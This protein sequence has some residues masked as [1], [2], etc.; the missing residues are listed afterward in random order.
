VLRDAKNESRISV[1]D[2]ALAMIDAVEHPQQIRRR[3]PVGY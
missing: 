1:E 3:F 2:F